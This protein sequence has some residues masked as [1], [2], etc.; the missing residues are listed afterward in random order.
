MSKRNLKRAM[1]RWPGNARLERTTFGGLL[2]SELMARVRSK[3]NKT[4]EERLAKLLR[5]VGLNGWRRHQVVAGHPDF[6]WSKKQIAV[7]VDGCFWH[8]HNCRKG[9]LPKTNAKAWHNKIVNNQH[10]DQRLAKKLRR[11]HWHVLR[12]WECRLMSRPEVEVKR[13]RKM[14]GV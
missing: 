6:V 8:G 1:S 5:H 14:L 2:R 10:R 13:I 9:Q 4:T 12:I 3:G 7:F 11:E